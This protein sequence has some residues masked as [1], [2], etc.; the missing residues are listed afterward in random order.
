MVDFFLVLMLPN[1]GD[2]LQGIKR[3]IME[4]A[5]A[6]VINKADGEGLA[7]AQRTRHHY[8]NALNLLAHGGFWVPRVLSCSALERRGI[9]EVWQMVEE[10]RALASANGALAERRARQNAGWL[11]R[12]IAERLEQR[13]R[14]EPRVRE[15]LPQLEAQVLRGEISARAATE[16]LFGD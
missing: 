13:F 3:G 8:Q 12:L 5:D 11:K 9:A 15:L 14:A 6:L 10:Y 2:E 4:L 7:G 1:A 16:K